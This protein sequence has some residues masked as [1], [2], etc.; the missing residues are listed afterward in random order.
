MFSP[1]L[2]LLRFL[3]TS[4][5]PPKLTSVLG[6]LTSTLGVDFF[7]IYLV[8]QPLSP[9]TLGEIVHSGTRKWFSHVWLLVW[10]FWVSIDFCSNVG[11]ITPQNTAEL[12]VAILSVFAGSFLLASVIGA[13][14][15]NGLRINASASQRN[16]Y[17]QQLEKYFQLRNIPRELRWIF[18]PSAAHVRNGTENKALWLKVLN[19]ALLDK[20]LTVCSPRFH[21][22]PPL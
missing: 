12:L 21:W 11:D 4:I 15:S 9:E 3:L 17:L 8:N 10:Q 2:R 14:A 13:I 20:Y 18:L 16:L 22:P 5:F 19:E 1:F 7:V 6:I